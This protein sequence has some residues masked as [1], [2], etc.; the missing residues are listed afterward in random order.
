[1]K[2]KKCKVCGYKFQKVDGDICP[3]CLSAREDTISCEDLS[4]EDHSHEEFG[5]SRQSEYQN[6]Q[7]SVPDYRR[8]RRQIPKNSG[9]PPQD[10]S[11]GCLGMIFVIIVIA[12]IVFK[13]AVEATIPIIDEQ[14]KTMAKSIATKISNEQATNVMANYEYEDFCEVI[15]DEND[16]IKMIGVNMITINEVISDIPILIQEELEKEENSTFNIKLRKL[17]RK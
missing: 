8:Y 12:I 13:V 5:E 15:K 3:E 4:E 10:Q 2:P 17:H 16:N 1:M 6:P 11:S 9:R 14:C 7:N